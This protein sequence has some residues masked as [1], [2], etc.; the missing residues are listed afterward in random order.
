MVCVQP[1]TGKT[2]GLCICNIYIYL[3]VYIYTQ[4]ISIYNYILY[5]EC[6][7]FGLAMLQC[8]RSGH[9]PLAASLVCQEA[10]RCLGCL[11]CLVGLRH[12]VNAGYFGFKLAMV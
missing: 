6:I 8:Y 4:Y 11:W 2:F 3:C 9:V 1:I 7:L 10:L 5:I 12:E